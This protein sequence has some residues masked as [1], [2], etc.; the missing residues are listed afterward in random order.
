VG[1][2]EWARVAVWVVEGD[3]VSVE[4][5]LIVCGSGYRGLAGK[6]NHQMVKEV[7]VDED[8]DSRRGG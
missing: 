7:K 3:G 2:S 4:L 5:R 1:I 8:C 6:I